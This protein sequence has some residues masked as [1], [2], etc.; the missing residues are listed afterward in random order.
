M[1]NAMCICACMC[2]QL[3]MSR[4]G[5]VETVTLYAGGDTQ[6]PDMDRPAGADTGKSLLYKLPL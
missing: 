2:V 4:C 6:V 5:A 1:A 3:R